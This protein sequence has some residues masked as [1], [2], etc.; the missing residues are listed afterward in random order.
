MKISFSL[1]NK[2]AKLE[3]DVEKLIEKG[4]SQKEKLPPKKTRFQIKQEE[5]RKNAELKH[6]QD[7]Q[8]AFIGIGIFAFL[9]GICLIFAILEACGVLS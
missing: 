3:A 2:E 8:I 6:K 1:K 7:M 4:M 5:K 9:L